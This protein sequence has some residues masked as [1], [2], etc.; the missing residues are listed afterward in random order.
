MN[1]KRACKFTPKKKRAYIELLCRG[2]RRGISAEAVGVTLQTVRAHMAADPGF[3]SAVEDA[4]MHAHEMVE[5]ALFQAACSGNVPSMIFY[6]CNRVPD[7]WINVQRSEIKHQ[8]S[9]LSDEQL[10]ARVTGALRRDSSS[11]TDSAC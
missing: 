9:D 1:G 8:F 6:L 4:E 3:A 11:G 10:I 5:D 7:K 2:G